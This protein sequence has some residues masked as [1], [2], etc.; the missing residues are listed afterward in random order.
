MLPRQDTIVVEMVTTKNDVEKYIGLTYVFTGDNKDFSL[1]L[2]IRCDE[3]NSH[4]WSYIVQKCTDYVF[5][6]QLLKNVPKNKVKLW[7]ITKTSTHMKI[8]CNDVTVLD[9]NFETDSNKDYKSIK[10]NWS[11]QPKSLR[12]LNRFLE[13]TFVKTI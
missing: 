12:I 9:F 8:V 1:S 11:G 6:K 10:N 7:K 5:E 3:L 4:K 2:F 13:Y